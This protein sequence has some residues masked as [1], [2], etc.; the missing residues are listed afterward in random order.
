MEGHAGEGCTLLFP[1][2]SPSPTVSSPKLFETEEEDE[3]LLTLLSPPTPWPLNPQPKKDKI[4][5]AHGVTTSSSTSSNLITTTAIPQANTNHLHE[6]PAS[7]R[8]GGRGGARGGGAG[9]GGGGGERG[10][11]G[12]ARGRGDGGRRESDRRQ[13]GS[14]KKAALGRLA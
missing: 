5:A 1:T 6:A 14:D 3:R 12:G 2:H 4:L 10:R 13:R 7:T 9:R 11:G 8:G